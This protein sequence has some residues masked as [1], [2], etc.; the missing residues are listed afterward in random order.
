[1][2]TTPRRRSGR[3]ATGPG[4]PTA[5]TGMPTRSAFIRTGFIHAPTGIT[6]TRTA[7]ILIAAGTPCIG[8]DI[9]RIGTRTARIGTSIADTA[10]AILPTET[11]ATSPTIAEALRGRV[12]SPPRTGT[13]PVPGTFIP[14]TTPAPSTGTERRPERPRQSDP[15]G[16][17]SP[18]ANPL[19]RLRCGFSHCGKERGEAPG[20]VK[21]WF[22]MAADRLR[23]LDLA[24]ACGKVSM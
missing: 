18:A 17:R 11:G 23:G 5:A 9:S 1:M 10:A 15:P 8:T 7:P 6:V 24:Q 16:S 4:I 22:H 21:A 19:Q 12:F 20:T 2:P 13:D 3:G 14:S